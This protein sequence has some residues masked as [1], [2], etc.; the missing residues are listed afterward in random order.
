MVIVHF[1][2]SEI[3]LTQYSKGILWQI[4]ESFSGLFPPQTRYMTFLIV[5]SPMYNASTSYHNAQG[6]VQ[7]TQPDHCAPNP[8]HH[9]MCLKEQNVQTTQSLVMLFHCDNF[10]PLWTLFLAFMKPPLGHSQ[11]R[12][13]P[14]TVQ[15]FFLTNT[16]KRKCFGLFTT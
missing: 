5:F 3:Y 10:A 7:P 16:L 12:T 14:F 15:S 1:Y 4:S 11:T 13:V 8:F 9:F 6:L 2:F